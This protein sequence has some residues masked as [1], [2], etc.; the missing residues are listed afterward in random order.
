MDTHVYECNHLCDNVIKINMMYVNV[1]ICLLMRAVKSAQLL[2]LNFIF[3]RWNNNCHKIM[4]VEKIPL[5][6]K[7]KTGIAQAYPKR[8]DL[9]CLKFSI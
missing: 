8:I 7:P 5:L 4:S 9:Y 6:G 3:V 2:S 1:Y